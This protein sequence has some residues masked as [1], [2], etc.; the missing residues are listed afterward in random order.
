MKSQRGW[1]RSFEDP[2]PLPRGRQL[3]KLQDAGNYITRLPKVEHEAAEWQAAVE[4][5]IRDARRPDD[6]RS[7]RHHAGVEPKR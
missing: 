7:D 5:P 3:V 1:K 4:A 2:I 6:V